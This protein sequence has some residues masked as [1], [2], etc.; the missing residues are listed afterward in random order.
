MFYARVACVLG[1]SRGIRNRTWHPGGL[2]RRESTIVVILKNS[3][4]RQICGS[5]TLVCKIVT[6]GQ[7]DSPTL[8]HI[9]YKNDDSPI[10]Q[11]LVM[12]RYSKYARAC[13]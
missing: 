7:I 5:F 10:S 2:P 6:L 12:Y 9:H 3:Y 1:L 4:I 13:S 11:D 8:S